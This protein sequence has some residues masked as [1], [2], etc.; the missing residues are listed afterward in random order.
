MDD[1]STSSQ[2]DGWVDSLEKFLEYIE[3]EPTL[4]NYID[5]INNYGNYE[6][7][8]EENSL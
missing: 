8:K 7:A 3:S 5:R 4:K 6:S 2:Y 1:T